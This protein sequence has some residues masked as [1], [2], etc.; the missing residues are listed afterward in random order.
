MLDRGFSEVFAYPL[1]TGCSA[2][3]SVAGTG[4]EIGVY[5]E[6]A[7]LTLMPAQRQKLERR[8][9]LPR[10]V[11]GAVKK[12]DKLGSLEYFLDGKCVKSIPLFADGDVAEEC[13]GLNFWQKLLSFFGIYV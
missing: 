10:I 8:V 5:A 6:K 3:V 1:E 13:D 12:G 2:K 7:T 4:K 9:L 11:Y